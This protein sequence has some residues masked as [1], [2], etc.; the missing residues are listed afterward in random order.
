M[1]TSII[2]VS[3]T[4][5]YRFIRDEMED[6]DMN[7]VWKSMSIR[8][9][10]AFSLYLRIL[11]DSVCLMCNEVQSKRMIICYNGHSAC[12]TCLTKL[13]R[14]GLCREYVIL[15]PIILRGAEDLI[16][17]VMTKTLSLIRFKTG[18]LVDVFFLPDGWTE[19]RIIAIDYELMS[20]FIRAGKKIVNR[21]FFSSKMDVVHTHTPRWRDMKTLVI[22]KKIEVLVPRLEMDMEWTPGVIVL[23]DF[24]TGCIHVGFRGCTSI[25]I[26]S[27][28]LLDTDR[29][30]LFPTYLDSDVAQHDWIDIV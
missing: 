7:E 22:G 13:T 25:H 11:H 9:R 27:F 8:E 21:R 6:H 14:C 1:E 23:R 24:A 30:A 29:I 10:E 15:R 26:E 5:S 17:D 4:Q 19:G 28:S 18:D 20:F 3:S 2:P 12:D 16:K